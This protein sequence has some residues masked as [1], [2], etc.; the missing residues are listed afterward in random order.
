MRSAIGDL[1]PPQYPYWEG[2]YEQLGV[3]AEYYIL[4]I[5]LR[6]LLMVMLLFIFL[7]TIFIALVSQSYEDLME[8]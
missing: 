1:Q 8:S 2:R 4:M 5:W 7:L 3:V 6:F